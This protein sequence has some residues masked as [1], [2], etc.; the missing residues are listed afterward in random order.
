MPAPCDTSSPSSASTAA[1]AAYCV[2]AP[3][4]NASVTALWAQQPLGAALPGAVSRDACLRY[5]EAHRH[6]GYEY[7]AT[8][9]AC[10]PV[11]G[12]GCFL[13]DSGPPPGAAA[14]E[15]GFVAC[16]FGA[17]G[18]A[19]PSRINASSAALSPGR[20]FAAGFAPLDSPAFSAAL[21]D[22]AACRALAAQQQACGFLW[23]PSYAGLRLGSCGAAAL[24]RGCCALNPSA[25]GQRV[26][27]GRRAGPGD[28]GARRVA[29]GLRAHVRACRLAMTEDLRVS[30]RRK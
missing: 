3:A 22:L 13:V 28:L 1:S 5:V 8:S 17:S 2:A 15:R 14:V 9:G 26:R 12:V 23:A 20:G 27:G 30:R 6:C 21:P 29:R 24:V 19:P 25:P 18:Y 4:A 11:P 7:N 16:D 10:T